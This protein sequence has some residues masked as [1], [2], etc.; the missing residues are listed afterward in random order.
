MERSPV[1]ERAGIRELFKQKLQTEW[2]QK[3]VCGRKYILFHR[4]KAWFN[5]YD[6]REQLTNAGK[7]L[8]SIYQN[9]RRLEF[10]PVAS[11]QISEYLLV[12]A[13]LLQNDRGDLIHYF[14]R[15]DIKD[16]LLRWPVLHYG[17]LGD[18]EDDGVDTVSKI[19]EFFERDRWAF[20]P[21]EIRTDMEKSSLDTNAII[22]FCRQ[23]PVN[24]K[25]GTAT[26][27]QV[28]LQEDFVS[29]ELRDRFVHSKVDDKEFG[30][31]REDSVCG[32]NH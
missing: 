17:Q 31:V 16:L 19:K 13:I 8:R 25:G 5:T 6:E 24:D 14:R 10:Q 1:G 26:V 21:V 3:A 32:N 28:L 15:T 20:C 2:T 11:T 30:S 12:F 27:F 29:K 4:V 23:Q 7:L 9:H 18:V 22:P